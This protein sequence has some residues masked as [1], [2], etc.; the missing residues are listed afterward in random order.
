MT[1]DKE[2]LKELRDAYI[3]LLKE[4]VRLKYEIKRLSVKGEPKALTPIFNET[5]QIKLPNLSK[6]IDD[7]IV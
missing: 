1:M 2:I 4:N 5:N 6:F 3:A 7:V